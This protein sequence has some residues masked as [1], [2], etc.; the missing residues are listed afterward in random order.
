MI[1]I[2]CVGKVRENRRDATMIEKDIQ[3]LNQRYRAYCEAVRK[4][5]APDSL[6]WRLPPEQRHVL[7]WKEECAYMRKRRQIEAELQNMPLKLQYVKDPRD[8]ETFFVPIPRET[9]VV[10]GE[11]AKVQ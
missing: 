2:V 1:T 8:G 9:P 7:Y 3:E 6:Y 4:T 10:K 5:R 11:E